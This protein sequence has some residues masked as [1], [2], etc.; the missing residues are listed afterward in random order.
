MLGAVLGARGRCET[1]PTPILLHG[2]FTSR[3]LSNTAVSALNINHCTILGRNS[4]RENFIQSCRNTCI[5]VFKIS[6]GSCYVTQAGLHMSLLRG[7]RHGGRG[8]QREGWECQTPLAIPFKHGIRC[9]CHL[10]TGTCIGAKRESLPHHPPK[11][12]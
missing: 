2:A 3:G 7:S 11:V 10:N 12:C 8:C 6:S 5:N 1:E 4:C 9:S